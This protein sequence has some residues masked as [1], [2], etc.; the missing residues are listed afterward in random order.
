MKPLRAMID[1]G[2]PIPPE[3]IMPRRMLEKI[4]RAKKRSEIRSGADGIGS[5]ASCFFFLRHSPNSHL[6][7]W[8][9]FRVD[10]GGPFLL[11]AKLE[12]KKDVDGIPG[13]K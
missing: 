6:A 5:K 1:K 9:D 12:E 3:L 10:G 8:L 4:M 11:A 7:R 2:V 13:P